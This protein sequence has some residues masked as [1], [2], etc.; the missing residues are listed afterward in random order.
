METGFPLVMLVVPVV[1][2]AVALAV[3]GYRRVSAGIGI[4]TVLALA[5]LLALAAPDTGLFAD[6]TLGLLGREAVLTPFIRSLF[7]FIYPAM[8]LFFLLAWTRPMGRALVPVGLAALSP[9]AGALMISPAGLGAV[10]LLAAAAVAVPALH[11]GKFAAAAPAWRYFLMVGVA[12]APILLATS[13][14]MLA[15]FSVG[16]LAP[17][18]ATLILLGGFPFHIWAA[19]LGRHITPV[20]AALA[21]GIGQLVVVTFL[22]ALLDSV[23]GARSTVQFQSAVRWSAVLTAL[24]GAFE[25]YRAAGWRGVVA[26]ALLLDMGFLLLVA[27]APGADGLSM[28]IPALIARFLSLLLIAVGL[29]AG[30]MGGPSSRGSRL[31]SLLRP[32]LLVYGSLSL[33][34]LPLTPGFAGRWPQLAAAGQG[35]G[36]WPAILLVIA[37]AAGTAAVVRLARRQAPS[38]VEPAGLA[39]NATGFEIGLMLVLLASAG[40]LGLFPGVLS[41]LASRMIGLG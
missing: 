32:A 21:L 30:Q 34:G 36:I 31:F 29:T 17:L 20:V 12:L 1:M 14:S 4:A 24:I 19:A 39:P 5:L 40:L 7:L 16:W 23:P 33:V 28:A 11:G 2:S 38:P 41:A 22:L 6:N 10:L 37:L 9:L 25:M 13:G 3:R 35:G 18:A 26:G 27:L 15:T 8:G